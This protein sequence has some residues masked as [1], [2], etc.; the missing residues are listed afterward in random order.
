MPYAPGLPGTKL[1]PRPG[2]PEDLQAR[3]AREVKRALRDA[4]K[5][6]TPSDA[7]IDQFQLAVMARVDLLDTK[8]EQHMRDESERAARRTKVTLAAI[9]AVGTI[10][11]AAIPATIAAINAWLVRE[12][13]A[14]SVEREV[15][16]ESNRL[17]REFEAR[18]ASKAGGLVVRGEP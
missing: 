6:Q 17:R 16:K 15:A 7:R 9:A 8:L 14:V 13:T 5:T 12:Q 18:E 4:P 10:L 2:S 11:A 1:P 3:V